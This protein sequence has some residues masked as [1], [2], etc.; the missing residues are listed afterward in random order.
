MG[1]RIL[2]SGGASER[3]Y[4]LVEVMVAMAITLMVMM[5]NL[6]IFNTA[7]K[8]LAYARAMTNATNLATTKIDSFRTRVVSAK[9]CFESAT[10]PTPADDLINP[11]FSGNGSPCSTGAIN[12]DYPGLV[13]EPFC[14]PASSRNPAY[15]GSGPLCTSPGVRNPNFVASET[16]NAPCCTSGCPADQVVVTG[17]SVVGAAQS[18]TTTLD[19]VAFTINWTTSFVDVDNDKV[20]DMTTDV[21]KVKITVV[22]T[23]NGKD[24]TVTL[25]TFTNGKSTT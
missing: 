20:C 21:L 5:A 8:N 23:Q 16:L 14:S 9:P 4:T 12:P 3:G 17:G 19:G 11:S 7:Q 1:Q 2:K 10:T 13:N 6:T 22:W 18:E 25:T 15:D 24:H